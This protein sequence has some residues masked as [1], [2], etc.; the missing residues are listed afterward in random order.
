M[1]PGPRQPKFPMKFKDI[2]KWW[3]PGYRQHKR[4][5]E[6]YLKWQLHN[7]TAE[8]YFHS[9]Y[10]NAERAKAAKD[11]AELMHL[12]LEIE[13]FD[14]SD[15]DYNH[16]EGVRREIAEWRKRR[17]LE[18]RRN[19][20][21]SRW[22]KLRANRQSLLNLFLNRIETRRMHESDIPN[23]KKPSKVTSRNTKSDKSYRNK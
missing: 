3:I 4:R 8:E 15:R 17:G 18:Q 21:K 20:I 23:L 2:L 13:G 9:H 7:S 12:K 19:A 14:N 1:P 11:A 16:F 5:L 6:V 22:T 10:S